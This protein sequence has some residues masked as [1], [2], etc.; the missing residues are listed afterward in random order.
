MDKA[1]KAHLGQLSAKDKILFKYAREM[2]GDARANMSH[3]E[4]YLAF[5]D[6]DPFSIQPE[7]VSHRYVVRYNHEDKLT[8]SI[9]YI[10]A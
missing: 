7:N 2:L 5:E 4:L 8:S 6:R 1:R 3:A 9:A 10:S